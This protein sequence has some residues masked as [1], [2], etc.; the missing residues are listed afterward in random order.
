MNKNTYTF[1]YRRSVKIDLNSHRIGGGVYAV[2]K[3][4][5]KRQELL[6]GE[7]IDTSKQSISE[8]IKQMPHENVMKAVWANLKGEKLTYPGIDN[9]IGIARMQWVMIDIHYD[10][11]NFTEKEYFEIAKFA[12]NKWPQE[13][14]RVHAD[15]LTP[16]HYYEVCKIMAQQGVFWAP[17]Y[18]KLQ[19]VNIGEGRNPVFDIM[20]IAWN[21]CEDAEYRKIL[22]YNINDYLKRHYGFVMKTMFQHNDSINR[23]RI[24]ES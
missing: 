1:K 16:E 9:L 24:R 8:Q 12:M 21:S 11:Y 18:N 22:N 5:E 3:E 2:M 15:K 17:D 13:A 23:N 14:R 10:D 7:Q 6:Q 20:Q 19:Q 4:S